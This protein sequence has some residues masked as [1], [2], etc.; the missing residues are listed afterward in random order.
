MY[1]AVE[2]EFMDASMLSRRTREMKMK[3][4]NDDLEQRGEAVI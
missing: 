2:I 3:V 1:I 4:Y